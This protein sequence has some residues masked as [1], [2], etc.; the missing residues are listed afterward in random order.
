M[1]GGLWGLGLRLID[2]QG[3]FVNCLRDNLIDSILHSMN[4]E[5]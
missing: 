1:T 2:A 5:S 4:F 3:S